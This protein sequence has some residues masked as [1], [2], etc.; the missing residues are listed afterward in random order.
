MRVERT[1]RV[2]THGVLGPS[3]E[4]IWVVAHGYGQL[5]RY[6]IRHFEMLDPQKHFVIAPEGLSRAYIGGLTG[7]VGASWMTKEMREEEILDY[8]QFIDRAVAS[9]TDESSLKRCKVIAFGFSQ[10]AATI[11][12]WAHNSSM[13]LHTMIC[14]GGVPAHEFFN[15]ESF[16]NLPLIFVFG[17][18]DEY[19]KD[20]KREKLKDQVCSRGWKAKFLEFSGTHQLEQSL[21]AMISQEL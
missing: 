6:F 8:L 19:L 21:I 12:R 4:Q 2:Y 3:T 11:S 9:H 20:H 5:A 14:W 1:A 16:Q 10:G 17:D 18:K 15:M 7:R 13:T